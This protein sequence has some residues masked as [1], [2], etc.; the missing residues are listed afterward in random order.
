[1]NLKSQKRISASILKVGRNRVFFDPARLPEIK[2]AITRG[3][4]KKL[5]ADLAIQAKQENGTSRF[6][7]RKNLKQKKKGR[8]KG[9]GSR[10]GT[11][12]TRSHGKRKWINLIRVQRD[13]IKELRDK[14]LVTKATYHDLYG[15]TKGG[16][17]R[18]KRHIKLYLEEHKLIQNAKTKTQGSS[19]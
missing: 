10:K 19:I 3:D 18:S 4:L 11:A 2:E 8:R 14:N 16:M 7:I 6:R 5:I 1:M 15:K 12:K 13:F 9:Q 17:F